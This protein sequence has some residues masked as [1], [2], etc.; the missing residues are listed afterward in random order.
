MRRKSSRE[1]ENGSRHEALGAP[2]PDRLANPADPPG[3]Y[4]EVVR[5]RAGGAPRPE[6]ARE[7]RNLPQA[8]ARR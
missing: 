2:L 8:A 4:A 5:R 6:R 7:P 1:K 3:G